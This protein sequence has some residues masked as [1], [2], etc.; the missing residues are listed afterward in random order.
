[1]RTVSWRGIEI[2]CNPADPVD[3][4]ILAIVAEIHK[5]SVDLDA[6]FDYLSFL[7]ADAKIG[8]YQE[9]VKANICIAQAFA[10]I[11]ALTTT[12]EGLDG[13]VRTLLA[14]RSMA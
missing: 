2:R 7:A 4:A 11:Q 3:R 9:A 10:Q 1:M 13:V 5:T 14:L 8:G 12:A 6:E